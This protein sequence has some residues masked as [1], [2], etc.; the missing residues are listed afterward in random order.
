MTVTCE[1]SSDECTLIATESRDTSDG[2][3]PRVNF[4]SQCAIAYDAWLDNYDPPDP[5]GEAFR[6]DEAAAFERERQFNAMR[7]K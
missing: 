3:L 6:G 7:F 1:G 5:D 2:Y 4:C